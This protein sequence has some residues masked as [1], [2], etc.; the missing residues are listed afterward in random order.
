MTQVTKKLIPVLFAALVLAVLWVS[1]PTAQAQGPDTGPID[2]GHSDAFIAPDLP[3]TG[4]ANTNGPSVATNT[5]ITPTYYQTSEY[6]A[7]SV[8]VGIVLVESDGSID[9]STEDWTDAEKQQ[10]FDEIVA[11]LNWWAE[12]EPRANLSFVYDDHFSNPL[13]TSVEPISRPHGDQK[14]WI[15]DAM[16]ALGYDSPSYFTNV[17]DY[18]NDLRATYQTNW[19]FTIFVVD[20][21]ADSNDS[22][23]DGY[24]AYAYL[25]GPFMVM[26][27]ANGGH[28]PNN[29]GTVA[30]HE[31]GHI[32]Y[33]LDQYSNAQQTCTKRS[34]YLNVENQNSQYGDCSSDVSSVMRTPT[35]HVNDA[36]DPYAAGQIGW[37]DSDGDGILD[38]LD[39]ELPINI[40]AVSVD[41]G[42]VTITGT[43]E[44]VPYPSPSRTS[45]TINTLT[46]V[47]YRFNGGNWQ[48][49]LADD[50][51]FDGTTEGFFFAESLSSGLYTMEVAAVDSAGNVSDI[52]ATR[53]IT[54]I[55]PIDGGLNTELFLAG[56]ELVAGDVA[57]S[58]ILILGSAYH[59]QEGIVANV[60]YRIDGGSWQPADAQDD[61]YNSNYEP[62]TAEIGSLEGGTHLIEARATDSDGNV[63]VNVAAQEI[64]VASGVSVV[65]LPL[66]ANNL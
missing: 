17:R 57:D 53:T 38:P 28:G 58:T 12:M 8:A 1:A 47:Q 25:G 3:T 5:S 30:I 14:Y 29:M 62:F 63:E 20:S 22:F 40:G 54:V 37:R 13:T 4:G 44:I 6:M 43:A 26:T 41:G 55:D 24:F 35:A 15:T 10:V 31:I 36:L 27:Y 46:S 34:G 33:A 42:S 45:A 21:T 66:V 19:A 7:G 48:Q 9:P 51:T 2:K 59:L 56:D 39:T 64:T 23:S 65:F 61:T 18:V 32:F 60:E 49:A 11:A 50:S 52:Y 16:N